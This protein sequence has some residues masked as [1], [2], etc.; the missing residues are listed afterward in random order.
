MKFR[1]IHTADLHID[2]P[3]RGL[4][5]N[6]LEVHA[7]LQA[8]TRSAFE[9][10]V[11]IAIEQQVA[12]VLI[13]GD[14]FDGSWRDMKTGQWTAAQFRRLE[15]ESINV[16]YIRGNHDA[17]S[18]VRKTIKWPDNVCELSVKK[19]ETRIIEQHQVAI[20]GQ[21]F[22]DRELLDD[23]AANYPEAVPGHFNVAMLHTSLT[24]SEGHDTYAPTNIETLKS[25]G[26]DYWALGHIHIRSEIPICEEPYIA[27]SGNTQGRHIKET[28][29]KGCNVISVENGTITTVD[30]H[31]TD[32]LRW[33][34]I[35]IELAEEDDLDSALDKARR[36][37]AHTHSQSNGRFSAVRLLLRGRCQAH[38]Q[39][40]DSLMRSDIMLRIHDLAASI[41]EELWIEKIKI[42]TKPVLSLEQR[43]QSSD[44]LGQLLHEVE[45]V[46]SDADGVSELTQM[47]QP[48]LDKCESAGAKLQFE[49]DTED[50]IRQWLDQAELLLLTHLEDAS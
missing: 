42:D 3:L 48:V 9:N 34:E 5:A 25:K 30:F 6:D 50:Q 1:F 4:A 44:M 18:V 29:A 7:R 27:Y 23:I 13:A 11:D 33:H 45:L 31:E 20:H 2:S 15:R 10:V 8:A 37:L 43:R 47:I 41:D 17:E 19:P 22:K 38:R 24:G 35:S 12:F 36:E 39:L 49:T 14:L 40:G 21:G 16:Y 28:G 32:L 46:R 26:Y